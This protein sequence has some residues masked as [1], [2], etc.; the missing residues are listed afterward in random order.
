MGYVV[1]WTLFGIALTCY[2]VCVS[3]VWCASLSDM[4]NCDPPLSSGMRRPP[5]PVIVIQTGQRSQADGNVLDRQGDAACAKH[6][7]PVSSEPRQPG[8]PKPRARPGILDLL[9]E[10]TP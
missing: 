6:G 10:R 2:T 8:R 1:W 3:L 4:R 5:D 7:F 9:T